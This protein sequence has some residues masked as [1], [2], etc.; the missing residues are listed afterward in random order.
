MTFHNS[1]LSARRHAQ[2]VGR[3]PGKCIAIIIYYA[4]WRRVLCVDTKNVNSSIVFTLTRMSSDDRLDVCWGKGRSKFSHSSDVDDGGK[5]KSTGFQNEL[6]PS[7]CGAHDINSTFSDRVLTTLNKPRRTKHHQKQTRNRNMHKLSQHLGRNSKTREPLQYRER[8]QPGHVYKTKTRND[9][10]K[11][12]STR[13][14][15]M[16]KAIVGIVVCP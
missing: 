15:V 9:T 4:Y 8:L 11:Q 12:I 7:S 6:N 1:L 2:V 10:T 14:E 13:F 3:S 5:M 16:N